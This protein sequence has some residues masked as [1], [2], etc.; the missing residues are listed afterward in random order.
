MAGWRLIVWRSSSVRAARL[1]QDGAVDA[2]LADVVQGGGDAD[3]LHVGR[4]EAEGLREC[5]RKG[6]DLVGVTR[7]VGVL[8]VDGRSER[9]DR[10]QERVLEIAIE[11][12]VLD[13]HAQLSGDRGHHVQVLLGELLRCLR[14]AHAYHADDAVLG[15]DRSADRRG[16]VVAKQLVEEVHVRRVRKRQRAVVVRDPPR[17]TLANGDVGAR[18]DL[19]VDAVR[20]RNRQTVAGVVDEHD[21]PGVRAG[22]RHKL[23]ERPVEHGVEIDAAAQSEG[24]LVEGGELPDSLRLLVEQMRVAHA[25]G[26]LGHD[27][28]TG[29]A[30][31]GWSRTP[32]RAS[33]RG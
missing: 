12:R 13:R 8:G 31:L 20:G 5:D 10:A 9:G 25:D 16:D 4:I 19:V 21:R 32:Q 33:A 17:D 27:D 28:L 29:S 18:H 3:L 23:L 2:D 30:H 11:A 1:E 15:H 7:G 24:E 26:R 14:A 6:G 22:D